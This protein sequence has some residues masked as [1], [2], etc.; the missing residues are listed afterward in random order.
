MVGNLDMIRKSTRSFGLQLDDASEIH[1]VLESS[2]DV[3]RLREFFGRRVL[4]L[5]KAV[6]RPSGSLLRVD[7]HAV[8]MGEAQPGIFSKVPPPRNR[9]IPAP[10]RKA[11][12]QGWAALS[13]YFG[14]WPGDETDEQWAE[15][16]LEL[17]K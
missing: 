14:A 5:G 11:Q 3:E 7:A 16:L 9:R 15:M 4:V 2:E 8:E 1:G 13:G 17:K 12:G 10:A 6:Y